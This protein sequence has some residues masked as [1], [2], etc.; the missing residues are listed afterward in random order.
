MKLPMS[1]PMVHAVGIHLK[2]LMERLQDSQLLKTIGGVENIKK[3]L[4]KVSNNF[5][6]LRAIKEGS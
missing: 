5:L 2:G 1:K 6:K 4:T 3:N